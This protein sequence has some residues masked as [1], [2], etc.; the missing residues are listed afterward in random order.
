MDE[1]LSELEHEVAVLKDRVA[2][3]VTQIQHLQL[4]TGAARV[5][6]DRVMLAPKPLEGTD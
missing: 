5:D 3:M 1:R 6:L 4:I 2:E